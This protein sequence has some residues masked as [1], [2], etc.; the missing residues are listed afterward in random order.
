MSIHSPELVSTERTSPVT[1]MPSQVRSE[2]GLG[3][4]HGQTLHAWQ[5]GKGHHNPLQG[6]SPGHVQ[7][8]R[9]IV[10]RC[11]HEHLWERLGDLNRLEQYCQ[12]PPEGSEFKVMTPKSR[13]EL[14]FFPCHPGGSSSCRRPSP[15]LDSHVSRYKIR[16][17]RWDYKG[18]EPWPHLWCTHTSMHV[19]ICAR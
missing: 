10:Y 3:T 18:Q 1:G 14:S 17:M 13:M 7:D 9:G 11:S 8:P 19:H 15:A 2:S 4:G 6:N 16:P 12:R 5:S